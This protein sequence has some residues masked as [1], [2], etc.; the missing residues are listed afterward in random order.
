MTLS[1]QKEEEMVFRQHR[2]DK[3]FSASLGK[4]ID[5]RSSVFTI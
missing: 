5:G 3:R 4:L 2:I 1:Q